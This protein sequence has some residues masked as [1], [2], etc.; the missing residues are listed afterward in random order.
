MQED[1]NVRVLVF[2]LP[3]ALAD[4]SVDLIKKKSKVTQ[5]MI[6]SLSK[7]FLKNNLNQA[8]INKSL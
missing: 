2:V 5:K 6:N 3:F 4:V 7:P 8:I 1:E